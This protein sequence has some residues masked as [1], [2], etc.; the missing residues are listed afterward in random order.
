MAG[1]L[2][3]NGLKRILRYLRG[4]SDTKICYQKQDVVVLQ[5]FADA[6]FAN[7]SEDRKSISGYV[8]QVFGNVVSWSTKR[9]PTVSLSSTEAELIALCTAAKEGVW[10]SNLLSELQVDCLPIVLYEDNIPCIRFS[11]EP[12]EH[13]RMKH[14]D[15]KFLFIRELVKTG[16]LKIEYISTK[17]QPA[18]ALT[19]ALPN[20][21]HRKLFA[22][23][24]VEIEGRC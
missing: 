1:D 5:G 6:D 18:D 19:K 17:E 16:R 10:L 8:F 15:V 20:I 23:L 21:L 2:H 22:S 11:E 3:W 4:T 24:N 13:Q 7:D 9:Q 12:R 14:I